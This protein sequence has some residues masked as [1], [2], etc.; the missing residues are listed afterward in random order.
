MNVTGSKKSTGAI[1][2]R[3]TLFIIVL[4]ITHYYSSYFILIYIFMEV[5]PNLMTLMRYILTEHTIKMTMICSH[6]V[7]S[8]RTFLLYIYKHYILGFV[9][10]NLKSF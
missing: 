3:K 2:T 4:Q 7:T 6:F 1:L 10:A 9:F 5:N 8:F